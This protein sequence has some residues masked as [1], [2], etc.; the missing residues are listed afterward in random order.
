M[1]RGRVARKTN[2]LYVLRMIVKLAYAKLAHVH[3][4][5]NERIVLSIAFSIL[6]QFLIPS[7]LAVF[8]HVF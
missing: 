1:F 2:H 5:Q 8:I 4:L 7:F 3:L 6:H